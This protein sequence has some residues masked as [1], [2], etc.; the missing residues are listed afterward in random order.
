MCAVPVYFAHVGCYWQHSARFGKKEMS[1]GKIYEKK[2]WDRGS[3]DILEF[4]RIES[5]V[6]Q[7]PK[8]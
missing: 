4:E 3:S 7:D 1:L 6:S 2:E 8:G 5:Q